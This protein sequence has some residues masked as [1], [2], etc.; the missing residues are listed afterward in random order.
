MRGSVG[1]AL[2]RRLGGYRH[3]A[4][5]VDEGAPL[6]TSEPRSVAVI[7]GG[8]AGI[9]AASTLAERGLSVTLFEQAARIGGKIGGERVSVEGV[10]YELDHGFHAFFR[11]YYNLND[12]LERVGALEG[13][14][15]IDD[16]AILD[17]GG[18]LWSFGD[19]ET[20]PG[21]NLL[22]LAGK[23][24]YRLGEVLFGGARKHLNV[25]L[26]YDPARTFAAHDRTSFAAWADAA[27]LPARLRRV[28]ATFARAFF[29]EE[30]RLSAA[31]VVKAFHF[32]YLAHDHGLLYDYPAEDYAS[33]VIAKIEEH[34]RRVGVTSRTGAAVRTVEVGAGGVLVDGAA[35][36]EVVIATPATATRDLAL[37]SPGLRAACPETTRR[38]ARLQ[39][40][41]RYAVLRA[42]IDR[43]LRPGLPVFVATE[44][45]GL[46][47]AV[48]SYHRITARDARWVSERGGGA[49][50]ELHCYAVPDDVPDDEAIRAAM[51]RALAR[52]FPELA[53]ATVAHEHLRVR[54]DFTALYV[55]MAR[56]RPTT[57]TESPHVC[58][59]GDWVKLPVPAMLMEGAFSSGLF[60]ANAILRR[61]GLREAP[62][63]TVPLRGLLAERPG[64][65]APRARRGAGLRPPE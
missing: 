9:A 63:D 58:L 37:R 54:D 22:D 4:S 24:V 2:Q 18:R 57:E 50:L 6:L 15:A 33:A 30:H 7:G 21:L 55:G 29:G 65:G 48:A 11:H 56:D 62:I 28:L 52:A 45:A 3:R 10:P 51:W 46:L 5:W 59:A 12:F 64:P 61:V 19:V 17:E 38:L 47:D 27:A 8:L 42:W 41:P 39:R 14:V 32:Y 20:T 60:A 1:A 13:M 26:E 31:E 34:L 53:D 23:D 16:Y 44:R 40:G 35:F 25:F 43:D 36:D 49:V